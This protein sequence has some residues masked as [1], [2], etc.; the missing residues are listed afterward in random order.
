[1]Q[2]D[3]KEIYKL[4]AQRT[5][6]PEQLYKD[7]G[8]FVFAD[9]YGF[10]KRPSHLI[11]KLKGVGSWHLRRKRMKIVLEHFPI[12]DRQVPT[13]PL[14]IFKY[15]NKKEIQAIFAERLKEYD[16]Y[17]EIRDEV[18]KIRHKTQVLLTPKQDE[19]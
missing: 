4:T 7:L 16:K 19:D 17:I 8:N 1:M 12:E 10:F 3:Y 13:S 6:V 5:G 15:E 2:S 14:E 11:I 18:R 9:L